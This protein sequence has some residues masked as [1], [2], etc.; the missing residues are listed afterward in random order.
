MQTLMFIWKI[1]M[2]EIQLELLPCSFNNLTTV[3]ALKY[4]K[5]ESLLEI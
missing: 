5:E 4:E 2:V 1:V 3:S